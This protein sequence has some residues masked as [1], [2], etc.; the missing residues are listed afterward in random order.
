MALV[1][2]SNNPDNVKL[3]ILM[4][5]QSWWPSWREQKA[6]ILL[7]G[8]HAGQ[9]WLW[10]FS[11]TICCHWVC[12]FWVTW[13]CWLQCNFTRGQKILLPNR[14]G[15]L[16]QHFPPL[17]DR[18]WA[19]P[20]PNFQLINLYLTCCVLKRRKAQQRCHAVKNICKE[21]PFFLS[22]CVQKLPR[23][24]AEQWWN[25][26]PLKAVIWQSPFPRHERT[27]WVYL[28]PTPRSVITY[29]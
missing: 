13:M 5:E 17:S 8:T 23:G 19:D 3:L 20:N 2:S 21:T 24:S 25:N 4:F 10:P 6:R 14:P 9:P 12:T 27:D 18:P 15:S 28:F 22:S 7:H 11:A 29:W 1:T 16:N 26:D